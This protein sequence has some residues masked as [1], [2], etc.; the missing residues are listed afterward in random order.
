MAHQ[1]A[2]YFRRAES[3]A[4]DIKNII[5]PPDDPEIAVLIASRAVPGKIISLEPAPVLF[6]VA[7][8]V[9]VNRPQHCGRG[10]PDNQASAYI[11]PDRAPLPIDPTRIDAHKRAS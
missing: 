5:N 11:W 8:L 3:V 10:S 4:S 6:F 9:A 7:L 1:R 2:F